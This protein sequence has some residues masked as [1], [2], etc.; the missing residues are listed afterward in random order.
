METINSWK[1]TLVSLLP[2]WLISFAV[3]AEG[4]PRPPIS[5]ALAVAAVILAIA[6]SIVLLWKWPLSFPIL[7]YYLI[8]FILL[9]LFDEIS[10]SYKTPFILLCVLILSIGIIG[11]QRSLFFWIGVLILVL[12]GIGTLAIASHASQNFWQVASDFGFGN[13]FPD[14]SGCPPLTGK[15]TPWWVLF[16]SF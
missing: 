15:E 9:Y 6:V 5:P 12:V 14:Y 11:Y 3:M 8:P 1:A 2:L 13:C 16:F 4:F 10:T 7:L